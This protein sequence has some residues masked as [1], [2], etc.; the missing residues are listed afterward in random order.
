MADTIDLMDEEAEYTCK[1]LRQKIGI[2]VGRRQNPESSLHIGTLNSIYAHLT[3]EFHTS[4]KEV[5]TP[6][7]PGVER[8]RWAVVIQVDNI[9]YDMSSYIPG[10]EDG[11]KVEMRPFRK[12][13]L[14]MIAMCLNGTEDQREWL[15]A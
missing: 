6:L 9:G 4:P 1:E 8:I 10:P 7:S 2:L 15:K 13:E 14:E 12:D 5:G 3:G 11:T